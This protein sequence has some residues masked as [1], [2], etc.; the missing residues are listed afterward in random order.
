MNEI[1]KVWDL[2]QQ[3]AD[4]EIRNS[5]GQTAL[6]LAL[7]KAASQSNKGTCCVASYAFSLSSRSIFYFFGISL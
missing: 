2:L 1:D 6:L 7:E 5:Q 3:G 4:I